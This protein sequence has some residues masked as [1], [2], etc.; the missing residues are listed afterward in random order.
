MTN[1]IELIKKHTQEYN[2]YMLKNG[3]YSFHRFADGSIHFTKPIFVTRNIAKETDI[4][5]LRPVREFEELVEATM[6]DTLV[7]IN[8]HIRF[9]GRDAIL[10][11]TEIAFYNSSIRIE[12]TGINSI[13]IDYNH[14]LRKIIVDIQKGYYGDIVF[15]NGVETNIH[16]FVLL[17]SY[18]MYFSGGGSH[19]HGTYV[20]YDDINIITD[21]ERRNIY[22][23]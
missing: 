20:K 1:T 22:W 12:Y 13:Y 2:E 23:R 7:T 8:E 15:I 9:R 4:L 10:D 6:D 14:E 21:T 3:K 11:E 18:L 16:D 5:P 17:E 19:T